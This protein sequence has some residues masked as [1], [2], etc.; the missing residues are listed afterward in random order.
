MTSECNFVTIYIGT[1]DCTRAY[2]LHLA[3]EV[4]MC[5][6]KAACGTSHGETIHELWPWSYRR[7]STATR[8]GVR[9]I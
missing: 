9:A 6:H 8:R 1:N 5:K 2:I 4:F 3:E 7:T